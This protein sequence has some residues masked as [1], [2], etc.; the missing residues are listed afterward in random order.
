MVSCGHVSFY[1]VSDKTSDMSNQVC[2]LLMVDKIA[3]S[4]PMHD[5]TVLDTVAR[6]GE[7]VI[8]NRMLS[9]LKDM[10]SGVIISDGAMKIDSIQPLSPNIVDANPELI[11]VKEKKILEHLSMSECIECLNMLKAHVPTA[12]KSL[13]SEAYYNAGDSTAKLATFSEDRSKFVKSVKSPKYY[14][15]RNI[16]SKH[17]ILLVWILM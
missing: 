8:S 1:R 4:G 12:V 3:D 9:Y 13:E 5:V 10:V 2:E 14:A 17:I 15:I 11:L 7:T 16:L 6:R